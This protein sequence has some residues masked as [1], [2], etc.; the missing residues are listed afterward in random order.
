MRSLSEE[1]GRLLRV[2][3]DSARKREIAKY[4]DGIHVSNAIFEEQ[5]FY[6]IIRR[7]LRLAVTLREFD[8]QPAF[9]A[10]VIRPRPLLPVLKFETHVRANKVILDLNHVRSLTVETHL[11]NEEGSI[12]VDLANGKN[13]GWVISGNDATRIGKLLT[14]NPDGLIVAYSAKDK[15]QMR[16]LVAAEI[17]IM[18]HDKPN[19]LDVHFMDGGFANYQSNRPTEAMAEF[20]AARR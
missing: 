6:E 15:V 3:S 9:I 4:G 11:N 19:Y 20:A 7:S 10:D 13:V 17:A 14:D 8:D 16:V 5:P 12:S 18:L 1:A 2:L